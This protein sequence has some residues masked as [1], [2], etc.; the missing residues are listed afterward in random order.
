MLQWLIERHERAVWI[1][2]IIDAAA[3]TGQKHVLEWLHAQPKNGGRTSK[4]FASAVRNGHLDVFK[5]LRE[6]YVD[7]EINL[8]DEV[9]DAISNGHTEVTK[10]VYEQPQFHPSSVWGVDHAAQAGDLELVHWLLSRSTEPQGNHSIDAAARRGHLEVV[11]WLHEN[12]PNEQPPTSIAMAAL[13]GHQN[14]VQW[15]HNNRSDLCSSSAMDNATAQGHLDVVKWLHENRTEGCTV[16]AMD[17]AAANG[18]LTVSLDAVRM[19]S[20]YMFA[21]PEHILGLPSTAV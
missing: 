14:V 19:E 3:S 15:L 7:A 2:Q 20:S 12:R 8:S 5:W 4:A 16:G 9:L 13:G 1:P 21:I 6:R 10:H 17:G 11:Q 18:P